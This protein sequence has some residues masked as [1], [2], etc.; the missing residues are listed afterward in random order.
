MEKQWENF[1]IEKSKEIITYD[2]F[3]KPI[4]LVAGFDISFDK[5]KTLN[6]TTKSC[7]YVTIYDILKDEIAYEDFELTELIIPYI[8]GFLGFREVPEFLKLYERIPS[9]FEPD[10]L[11]VDGYGILHVRGFGSASHLGYL[12]NKPCIGIGKTLLHIDGMIEKEFKLQFNLKCKKAGDYLELKG[13]SGKIYGAALQSVDNVSNP[14][15]VTIGHKISLE[16]SIKTIMKLCKFR[17][18]EPIR[19]SDI[20]SKVFLKNIV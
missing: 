13:I 7:A 12:T 16:T 19:N 15:Y 3:D 8:S 9:E 4:N 2:K 20:E 10:L 17:I 14:I 6:N 5:E 1:Q 11:L 18:P